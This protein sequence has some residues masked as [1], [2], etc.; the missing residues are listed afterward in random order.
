MTLPI[1][2]D[3]PARGTLALVGSGEYLPHMLPVDRYLLSLLPE[4]ARVVCMATAAGTESSERLAYWDR[5]GEGH[6]AS[7]GVASVH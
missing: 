3:L 6:F 2:V 4:P 1:T 5:L 7:L